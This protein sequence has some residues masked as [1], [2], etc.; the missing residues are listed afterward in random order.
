[1]IDKS[2]SNSQ[3][4]SDLAKIS[5]WALQWKMCFNSYPNKQDIEVHLSKKRDKEN[6]PPLQFNSTG[7]QIADIQNH[8]GL[9]LGSKLN[10]SEHIESKITKCNKIIGL[11]NV[12]FL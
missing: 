6:Y 1:M 3:L 11:M 10:L 8:L 5:K 12:N 2:H 7:V 4:N 9:I